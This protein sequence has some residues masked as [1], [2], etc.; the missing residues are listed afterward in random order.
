M[1]FLK[2]HEFQNIWIFCQSFD[3]VDFTGLI[4]VSH[5]LHNEGKYK[6]NLL[7]MPIFIAAAL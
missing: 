3:V 7:K 2:V 5:V 1:F 4:F 6:Q